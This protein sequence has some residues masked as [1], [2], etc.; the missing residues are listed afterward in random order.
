MSIKF[1]NML[2]SLCEASNNIYRFVLCSNIAIV[3][4]NIYNVDQLESHRSDA[5]G[6]HIHLLSLEH[7]AGG[8]KDFALSTLFILIRH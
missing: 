1:L 5:M 3:F 2:S 4:A 7:G 8:H 6:K